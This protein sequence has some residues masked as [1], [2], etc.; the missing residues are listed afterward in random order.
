MKTN[1]ITIYWAP[2]TTDQS[3]N[4]MYDEPTNLYSELIKEKDPLSKKSSFFSCPVVSGRMKNTFIFKNNIRTVC[5]YDFT[6]KDNP[7][8]ESK[9]GIGANFYKHSG[10]KDGA[11]INF[12]IS[13]IFFSEEPIT[14]FLNTPMMHRPKY[15]KN[16]VFPFGGYEIN[17]WFRPFN[18]EMQ[19]WDTKGTI[20][21]EEDEPLFY[22][23]LLTDRPIIL[24]R[25]KMSDELI[26]YAQGCVGAPKN[27]GFNLPLIDRYKRFLSTKTDKLVLKEIKKN[28]ID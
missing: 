24:K 27:Y 26:K 13:W 18:A 6:N 5:N 23:E 16:G 17:K 8:V 3:W 25:F 12:S 11:Y 20:V 21:I 9:E 4:L 2:A 10:L 15:L 7:I 1:P 28:I 22:L 14:A 19:M